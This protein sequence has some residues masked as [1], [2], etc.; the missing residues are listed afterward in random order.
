MNNEITNA[1]QAAD[2]KAQYDACAKRL[3]GHK[4]ILAHILVRTVEEFQGMNPKEVVPYIEGEPHISTASAEPG[5][6]NQRIGD[7]IVGLNTENKEINEGTIIFDIV[8]YV[9]MKNGLS[10]IIINVEAQKGETADYEILNRAIF[11]VCRLI[12]SQK[13]RDFKNSD[14]NG[15]KQV[16][17]IW[18]CMNLSE[19]S[20]S[21]I[22]LTQKNLIGSYE[23]KGNLNL[24]NIV[25]IGLA[26]ELPEH[27]EKYELHRLLG[28][29]LSQHLTE[30]ERLDII[31]MEYNIPLKK[32]LRKDVNVMCNLSEGIEERGIERGITIGEA[33]GRAVGESTAL[34]LIQ[35]LMKEGRT[36][37][38]ERASTD[39]E[40]RQKLYQEFHLI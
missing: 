27:D 35:L 33:R 7:R 31:G 20:M 10:Q 34:K 9:R 26:K 16:Y 4:I 40:A 37:D 3:L 30:K 23:W 21:H 39:P 24:F 36:A 8:F 18:V 13:E 11:Y 29:L 22:R 17:S 19:N 12:S 25:M 1:V 14:Y 32:N 15:I 6:T 28:T 5:L 38:I 2:L